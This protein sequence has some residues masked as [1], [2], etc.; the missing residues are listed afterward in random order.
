MTMQSQ[1]TD[2]SVTTVS[3]QSIKS[4]L[5]ADGWHE[6]SDVEFTQFA[7]SPSASA[8]QPN[9]LYGALRYTDDTNRKR[10]ITPLSQVFGVEDKSK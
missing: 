4:I 9:R 1:R 6:I 3:P 10:V 7:I 2:L 5:L 8:P